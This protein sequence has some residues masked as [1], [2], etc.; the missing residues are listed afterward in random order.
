[1]TPA[2]DAPRRPQNHIRGAEGE[3]IIAL[4]YD[5]LTFEEIAAQVGR[6]RQG[7]SQYLIRAD[8]HHPD[9]YAVDDARISGAI[10]WYRR[11]IPIARITDHFKI[12]EKTLYDYLRRRDV[13]LRY[14]KMS[15][16]NKISARR[17]RHARANGAAP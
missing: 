7:V 4:Y 14:P 3:R 1:M 12:C 2:I 6:T 5:G 9:E 16:A 8:I 10:R 11:G 15:A 17:R 13:P